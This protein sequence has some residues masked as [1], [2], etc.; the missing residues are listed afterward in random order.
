MS[1]TSTPQGYAGGTAINGSGSSEDTSTKGVDSVNDLWSDYLT[2]GYDI[3]SWSFRRRVLDT[4]LS[5]FDPVTGFNFVTQDRNPRLINYNYKFLVD[6]LK[7]IATGKRDMEVRVWS[8][9]VTTE[10][11]DVKRSMPKRNEIEKTASKLGID[12][13]PVK[14]V[15]QW[16]SQ[17]NGLDD[18]ICSMQL[19]F[20]ERNVTV[21]VR[22]I[23]QMG[24]GV[25]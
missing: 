13:S 16:C 4:A 3:Y 10:G 15:A 23:L 8:E 6:T 20:G 2:P 7:F 17:P 11:A 12:F 9:L 25:F 5:L 1:A 19:L 24:T 18:M 21:R 14:L 22:D